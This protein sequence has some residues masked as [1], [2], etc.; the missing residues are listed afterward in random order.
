LKKLA[1]IS[2]HPIQYN[3]PVF[4]LLAE[5]GNIRLKVFYTWEK[6]KDGIFDIKFNQNIKWDIPL[7]EGY[8][9][10]FVKNVSTNQGT[11]HF[12]GMI[13]PDLNNEIEAWGAVAVLIYGWNFHSHFKAM[14]Y[15]KG[16]IPVF[17]RGDST[18]LNNR[19]GIK[20][21]LRRIWLTYVYRFVD[22][23][24]Y[25]GT[26]N[27]KYYLKYGLK[28]KQLI[29]APHAVDNERFAD[30]NE[31]YEKKAKQ[32]RLQLG[33]KEDDLVF[34]FAGKFEAI[35]NPEIFIKAAKKISNNKIK[36]ILAGDGILTDNLK[37]DAK[38]CKNIVFLPFQNQS[39]MPIL[40]RLGDIYVITSRS[41][42]WGLALNES[43]ACGRAVL[44]SD[45]TGCVPDLIED[46]LNGFIFRSNDISD[47][48]DK[49]KK[50]S[51]ENSIQFGCH[52]KILIEN[53]SYN[54]LAEAIENT[55]NK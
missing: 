2:S 20:T 38:D 31:E 44:V 23:A 12:K 32:W 34:L 33:I 30:N 42:T 17:F 52:S 5:R 55:V 46:G 51:L 53:F 9:Y 7:L 37:F 24:F 28:E 47:L 1:I 16:K 27:K 13:N 29:F 19:P 39:M 49:I 35:K 54:K 21:L 50:F 22:Y 8:D 25:V 3:A 45:T 40:Y 43:M 18:I 4:K 14:K 11:H 48:I 15:F 41:E 6:S 26:N 10:Q 36:F